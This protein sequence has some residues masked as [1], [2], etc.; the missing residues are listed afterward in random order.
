ME[1]LEG[2]KRCSR[3]QEKGITHCLF[4]TLFLMI[5]GEVSS[6]ILETAT[7]RDLILVTIIFGG[8]IPGTCDCYYRKFHHWYKFVIVTMSLHVITS[9]MCIRLHFLI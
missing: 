7:R 8:S 2:R 9:M 4:D 1:K 5:T 6:L 3:F